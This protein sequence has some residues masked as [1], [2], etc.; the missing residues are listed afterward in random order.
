MVREVYV[1]ER[2]RRLTLII[3]FGS[4]IL[5]T[6][7]IISLSI[8]SSDVGFKE[9][10]KILISGRS[11]TCS[12][13]VMDIR[14]PRVLS[15]LVISAS[16]SVAGVVLQTLFKNPLIDPY[17]SGIASGA[18]FGATLSFLLNVTLLSPSSPYAI[19]VMAFLG[20]LLA[21]SLTI[22]M[23]NLTGGSPLTLVL[24]GIA[25]SFLFSSM[26][27]IVIIVG[28]ERVHGVLF[29]LF[30]SLITSSWR[31]LKVSVPI[32][33]AI[34]MY[35]LVKARTLNVLLLGDDEA[36]QLGVNVK[37]TRYIF[38][39]LLSIL[40]AVAVAFNG[41]IGFVGLIAPHISRLLVGNDHRLL[42]PTS[43][44]VGSIVLMISDVTARVVVSPAE[45][46]VGT[47]TSLIGVP[48]FVH[49]LLKRGVY[50]G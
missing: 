50:Y 41:V 14:L 10:I 32:T 27:T 35:T 48:L 20:A 16:L 23:S 42:I 34:T 24:S 36:K 5:F 44:Y 2:K 21:L 11:E 40:T 46:P 3:F 47:I 22:L 25:V 13:I 9:V 8:G 4:L 45:L 17:I 29:W 1:S 19:P 26:T 39:I 49:L 18:A 12:R 7:S 38:L 31:F 37:R 43:I 30:G 28:G 15:A 6:L 33:L